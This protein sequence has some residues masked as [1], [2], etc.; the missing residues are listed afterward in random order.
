LCFDWRTLSARTSISISMSHLQ[1]R[2]AS[3]WL[4]LPDFLLS[5]S[6]FYKLTGLIRKSCAY[7]RSHQA[8]SDSVASGY[9]C[10]VSF[11]ILSVLIQRCNR[12]SSNL[13]LLRPSATHSTSRFTLHCISSCPLIARNQLQFHSRACFFN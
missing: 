6:S 2:S 13:R 7:L 11:L 5:Y 8:S 1:S 3:R 12:A 9:R 10:Y 4:C